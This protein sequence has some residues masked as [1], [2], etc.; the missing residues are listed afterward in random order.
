MRAL[1]KDL[2]LAKEILEDGDDFYDFLG[3]DRLY[4]RSN[5]PLAFILSQLDVSGQDVLSVLGSSDQVFSFYYE[6]ANSVDAF[7][8][9]PLTEHYYYLRKWGLEH[10][11]SSFVQGYSNRDLYT[12][13]QEVAPQFE[14]EANSKVFWIHL[15]RE[16]PGLMRSNLF[17]PSMDA[18]IVPY[19]RDEVQLLSKISREALTFFSQD[20]S[21]PFSTDRQYDIV[22]L[23]NIFDYVR[24]DKSRLEICRDNLDCLLKSG[25]I[26][27][28]THFTDSSMVRRNEMDVFSSSFDYIPGAL[29]YSEICQRHVESY[30]IYQK[31]R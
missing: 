26:A 2:K 23:S 11:G 8:I 25:G 22:F 27:V 4:L 17:F 18:G 16:Y 20:F 14:N 9:H 3:P 10:R 28:L 24:G 29:R 1:Q 6:G 13:L 5:E 31:K 19:E 15:L 21:K 12:L 30:Y 7:D